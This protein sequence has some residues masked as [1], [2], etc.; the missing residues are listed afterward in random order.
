MFRMGLALALTCAHA[1]AALYSGRERAAPPLV[2]HGDGRRIHGEPRVVRLRV[3]VARDADWAPQLRR[4]LFALDGALAAWPGVRFELAELRRWERDSRAVDLQQLLGELEALDAGDGVDCVVGLLAAAP[5]EPEQLHDVGMARELGRH[6]VLRRLL[7]DHEQAVQLLHEWAHTL[8]AIHAR[9]EERIMNPSYGA[10]QSRFSDVE[11]QILELGLSQKGRPAWRAEL[12]RLVDER[13][14]PDWDPRERDECAG[15]SRRG[16][17]R[18]W[19][20]RLR[21]RR[22]TPTAVPTRSSGAPNGC[23][24]TGTQR[25]GARRPSCG[26]AWASR[27]WRWRM[28]GAPPTAH[29]RRWSAGR[30]RRGAAR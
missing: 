24:S 30:G 19:P 3:W 8:G 2:V 15:S 10:A 28:R 5:S 1:D 22:R 6:F 23:S 13:P 29:L 12:A 14:D 25:G 4:L 7:H 11:S 26:A 27:R 18:C 21:Q 20:R 16:P 9:G 17:A